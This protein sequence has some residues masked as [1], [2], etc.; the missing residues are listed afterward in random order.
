MPK[1]NVIDFNARKQEKKKPGPDKKKQG[2][3]GVFPDM[4]KLL[5]KMSILPR[6]LQETIGDRFTFLTMFSMIA[7]HTT[8]MLREEGWNPNDFQPEED[9]METFLRRGPTLY[10]DED[11]TQ[12]DFWNGPLF[13]SERDGT[14]YRVAS[15]IL[16]DEEGFNMNLDLLRLEKNGEKWDYYDDGKWNPG[17]PA[18]IFDFLRTARDAEDGEADETPEKVYEL[19]LSDALIAALMTNGIHTVKDLCGKTTKELLAIKGVG[20]KS[21][22]AIQDELRYYGLSLRRE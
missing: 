19:D 17:P 2:P 9:S 8:E 22:Q 16:M 12:N 3:D 4:D 11:G 6:P 10:M 7:V 1:D 21:I 5:S 18:Y 13:D 15:T 20:R 14:L